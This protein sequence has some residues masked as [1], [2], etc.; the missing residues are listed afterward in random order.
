LSWD[1]EKDKDIL[2]FIDEH[3][4][5]RAGFIKQVLKLYKYQF[6]IGL[7]SSKN[8]SSEESQDEIKKVQTLSDLEQ[9]L[10]AVIQYENNQD[11]LTFLKEITG[12]T[13]EEIQE[14]LIQLIQ[15]KKLSVNAD[16]IEH[17]N[18]QKDWCNCKLW[19]LYFQSI[20][21][22]MLIMKQEQAAKTLDVFL[23]AFYFKTF[24][25]YIN[26]SYKKKTKNMVHWHHWLEYSAHL[27]AVILFR[28]SLH[29][30]TS[31]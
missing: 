8:E 4:S 7:T 10:L 24:T 15:K 12:H 18:S 3:G 16:P 20:Y 26:I 30:I 6:N 17:W 11:Y 19:W 14:T 31:S 23:L 28:W 13:E 27:Y 1:L 5:T 9:K 22:N 21:L 25:L 29:K 2:N